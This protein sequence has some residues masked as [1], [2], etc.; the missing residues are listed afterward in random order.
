MIA[1]NFTH[2]QRDMYIKPYLT[3][4][5]IAFGSRAYKTTV[6][7]AQRL[8]RS[9]FIDVLAGFVARLPKHTWHSNHLST[10]TRCKARQ[11][12]RSERVVTPDRI[13]AE[14][15]SCFSGGIHYRRR[16]R[17]WVRDRPPTWCA[18]G[19]LHLPVCA[20]S[21]N[22]GA[23]DVGASST[24]LTVQELMVQKSALWEGGNK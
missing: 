22:S 2:F 8:I 14:Q 12:Q 6:Q 4:N 13:A 24:S 11:V 10:G 3:C 23:Q 9:A 20:D 5:S 1:C 19:L 7:S 17:H 18:Y 21:T 15:L 16:I